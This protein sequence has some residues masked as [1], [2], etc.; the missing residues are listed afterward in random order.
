MNQICDASHTCPRCVRTGC[1]RFNQSSHQQS[2]YLRINSTRYW[3]R[4]RPLVGHG[5]DCDRGQIALVGLE[6]T[7]RGPESAITMECKRANGAAAHGE[8]H[9]SSS[10]STPWSRVFAIPSCRLRIAG[11]PTRVTNLTH[12]NRSRTTR[13]NQVV[14]I[15]R[16]TRVPGLSVEYLAAERARRKGCG[17]SRY[18]RRAAR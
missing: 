12:D 10:T 6:C 4:K 15:A 11:M 14:A 9:S 5:R 8:T 2:D 16:V 13:L 18:R 17:K 1:I 3:S 7:A